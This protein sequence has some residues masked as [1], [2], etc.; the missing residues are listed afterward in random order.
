MPQRGW[1]HHFAGA[2]LPLSDKAAAWACCDQPHLQLA[3]HSRRTL[4]MLN[5]LQVSSLQSCICSWGVRCH[6][7]ALHALS[8]TAAPGGVGRLLG[9]LPLE[10][11]LGA[12]LSGVDVLA[13]LLPALSEAMA[14]GGMPPDAA[15]WGYA[16]P[17]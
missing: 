4:R 2:T 15:S 9:T 5:Q 3:R 1:Q 8:R 7:W 6:T 17:G 11:S 10:L 16:Y 12:V 13:A 14:S